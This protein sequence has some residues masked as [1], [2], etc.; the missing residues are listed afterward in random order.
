MLE[1][2]GTG[3]R[4]RHN[5]FGPGVVVNEKSAVYTISF[6]EHGLREIRK[7]EETEVEIIDQLDPDTDMVSMFDVE[8][9][10]AAGFAMG[11]I[12]LKNFLQ[13]HGLCPHFSHTSF[14]GFSHSHGVLPQTPHGFGGGF[15]VPMQSQTNFPQTSHG[16]ASPSHSGS[17]K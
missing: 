16:N 5:R 15:T 2:L 10:A 12:T 3:S 8:S 13:T 11:D 14:G 17:E 7:D 1:N 9:V 4:I 6:I